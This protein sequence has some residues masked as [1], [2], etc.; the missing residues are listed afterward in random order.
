MNLEEAISTAIEYE[1]R[2]HKTYREALKSAETDLAKRVFTT[3]SNEEQEHVKYLRDRLREWRK[4]GEINL[5]EI[6]SVLVPKELI[7]EGV[8]RLKTSLEKDGRRGH[9]GELVSL[10]KALE[11]ERE[12]S[13][14]YREMVATLDADGK[15]LFERFVEIE[16]GHLALVQA[17]IDCVTGSGYWFD[18]AEF[19]MEMA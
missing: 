18:T 4:T 6:N 5:A 1:A 7:E 17:E 10:R 13:N 3:L 14:F 19:S 12:T 9:D 2:V 15:R 8:E 16:E 11:V